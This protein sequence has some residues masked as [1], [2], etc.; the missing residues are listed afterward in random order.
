MEDEEFSVIDAKGLDRRSS[1]YLQFCTEKDISRVEVLH[2]WIL[3]VIVEKSK[4]DGVL[5][6][7][8]PPLLTRAIQELSDGMVMF[9]ECIKINDTQF[10]F[11]YAQ[12]SVVLLWVHWIITPFVAA[13]TPGHWSWS[14]VMAFTS[15]LC[16]WSVNFIA[17]ELENPFG[18]DVNDL[19]TRELQERMNRSLMTLLE[20]GTQITPSLNQSAPR[21]IKVLRGDRSSVSLNRATALHRSKA[22][23]RMRTKTYTQEWN[24]EEDAI[25]SPN[26][27]S[28]SMSINPLSQPAVYQVPSDKT[29]PEM[30]SVAPMTLNSDDSSPQGLAVEIENSHGLT[31]DSPQTDDRNFTRGKRKQTISDQVRQNLQEAVEV[32]HRSSDQVRQNLHE[33]VEVAFGHDRPTPVAQDLRRHNARHYVP[34]EPYVSDEPSDPSSLSNLQQPSDVRA[35]EEADAGHRS[36]EDNSASQHGRLDSNRMRL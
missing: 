9:N 25:Q 15:V 17:G 10:P 2:Q 36:L 5:S 14:F 7:C 19:P 13:A 23:N 33:A 8:P 18:D 20:P 16:L 11:P 21:E 6:K 3:Q 32:A 27:Q 4:D 30:N 26:S 31:K 12:M 34:D 35:L 24:D 1:E 28:E 22:M 29:S